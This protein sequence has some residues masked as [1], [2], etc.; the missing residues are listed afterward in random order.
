VSC[1]KCAHYRRKL[2]PHED[3]DFTAD[4]LLVEPRAW[5]LKQVTF[6]KGS[7]DPVLLVAASDVY[8]EAFGV[9]PDVSN[10]AKLGRT[11]KALGWEATK[12]D[13]YTMYAMSVEEFED[14]RTC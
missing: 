14:D 6:R 1:P 3:V 8:Y 11:L 12:R 10:V 4:Y 7:A 9:P 2:S 13:G 5:L